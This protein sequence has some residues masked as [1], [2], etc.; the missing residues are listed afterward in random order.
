MIVVMMKMILI[1][2]YHCILLIIKNSDEMR[3]NAKKLLNNL[4]EPK[5]EVNN[6]NQ[7]K[8]T[9]FIII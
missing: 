9:V 7:P 6:N 5:I 2:K 1:N 3:E 8:K 4:S